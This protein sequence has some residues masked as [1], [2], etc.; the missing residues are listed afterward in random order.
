MSFFASLT[1]LGM[2]AIFGIALAAL[3]IVQPLLLEVNRE[4]AIVVFKPFFFRTHYVVLSLSITVTVLALVTSLIS[5]NWWWFGVA[6]VMHLN[7]PYT[8]FMMMPTNRRLLADDI[9]PH[10][11]QTTHDLQR[12]KGL[13]AV[14]V[15]TNGIVFVGFI[16]IA[17]YT[18]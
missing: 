11:E 16:M 1:L 15:V 14:R 4:A 9:D 7:G 8:Y 6:M 5:S 12:W 13:H 3:L 10:D 17:V 2:G 18:L